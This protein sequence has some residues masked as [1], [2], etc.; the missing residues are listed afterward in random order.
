MAGH[1]HQLNKELYHEVK[2][3]MKHSLTLDLRY[4]NRTQVSALTLA[5]SICHRLRGFTGINMTPCVTASGLIRI[6]G[7]FIENSAG[8]TGLMDR[9]RRSLSEP[10]Q[11]LEVGAFIDSL[12]NP[13]SAMICEYVGRQDISELSGNDVI[14]ILERFGPE[15]KAYCA[16]DWDQEVWNVLLFY[17]KERKLREVVVCCDSRQGIF[18]ELVKLHG[19]EHVFGFNLADHGLAGQ[20]RVQVE[21]D[22]EHLVGTYART[23]VGLYGRRRRHERTII[24]LRM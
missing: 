14:A 19:V 5:S 22:E 3:S 6:P 13:L 1:L 18:G 7:C 12:P 2:S 8:L 20:M 10:L 17:L 4:L 11:Y 16:L 23:T 9:S 24:R 15:L 21:F